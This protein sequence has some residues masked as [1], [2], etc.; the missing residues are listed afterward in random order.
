MT[1]QETLAALDDGSLLDGELE[2][3]AQPRSRAK[4][5]VPKPSGEG[6]VT[7]T[8]PVSPES[9]GY[10][11]ETETDESANSANTNGAYH[12]PRPSESTFTQNVPQNRLA[13]MFAELAEYQEYDG[14]QFYCFLIRKPDFAND[15]FRR[16]ALAPENFSPF[17]ITSQSLLDFIP[18]IQEVNGNSGGRF[19][20]RISDES[21][22]DTGIGIAGF[23]VTDPII[24][25]TSTA[26]QGNS[27]T[28]ALIEM[29]RDQQQKSDERFAALLAEMAKP[30]ESDLEKALRQKMIKDIIDPAPPR[31][32]EFKP[33]Q[34]IGQI[35]ASQAMIATLSDQMAKAFNKNEPA[36]QST[37]DKVLNSEM[38][39]SYFK[40]VANSVITTVQQI[41]ASRTA[42]PQ[43]QP[44]P[45]QPTEG[46]PP[47]QQPQTTEPEREIQEIDPEV[48]EQI[49]KIL[50]ALESDEPITLDHPMLVEF[51]EQKPD[52]YKRLAEACRIAPL[53]TILDFIESTVP[54]A[55]LVSIYKED[56][57][58]TERGEKVMKRIEEVYNLL[59]NEQANAAA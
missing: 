39:M 44:I 6:K 18:T 51:K 31:E 2:P 47:L 23:V 57:E 28:S 19:E 12:S 53:D 4:R 55:A 38:A 9:L 27:E 13:D 17:P 45:Q 54:D 20:I 56:G 46:Y 15:K 50:T 37:L 5:P 52:D 10:E 33:E 49:E 3:K 59:K 7:V 36:E 48:M 29:I 22:I 14:Q 35:F 32:S 34:L 1:T 21:G 25:E 42:Q 43:S 30:K 24:K 8:Y 41:A 40:D 58:L 16:R 26:P 11:H